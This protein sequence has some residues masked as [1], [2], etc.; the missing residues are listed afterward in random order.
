MKPER[1]VLV[2]IDPIRCRGHAICS[3][4]FSEGIELDRWGY[5]RVAVETAEDGRSI[6]RAYRAAAACPNGAVQV[7]QLDSSGEQQPPDKPP[8]H[9]L[10]EQ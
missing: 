4:L 7:I 2:R 5:G 9:V 10:H 8:L 6:R 1:S 3:L